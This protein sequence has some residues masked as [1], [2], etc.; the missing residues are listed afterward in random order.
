MTPRNGF[1]C[2]SFDCAVTGY[3]QYW[4]AALGQLPAF[5]CIV[6]HAYVTPYTFRYSLSNYQKGRR[7]MRQRIKHI[8]AV[9]VSVL[10]LATS[11]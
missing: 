11:A 7:Q 10:T 5:S 2:Q 3:F 9:V 1:Y 4:Q 8:F 6:V